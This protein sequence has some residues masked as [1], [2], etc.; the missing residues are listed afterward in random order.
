LI[1]QPAAIGLSRCGEIRYLSRESRK[2]EKCLMPTVLRWRGWTF[3]FY[4]ADWREPPHVHA[5]QGRQEASS[6]SPIAA[7]RPH[8]EFRSMS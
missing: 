5:R 2:A 4:S 6:G 7:L 3:L 1:R 8:G